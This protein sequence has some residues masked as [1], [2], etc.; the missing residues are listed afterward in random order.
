MRYFKNLCLKYDNFIDRVGIFFESYA[1]NCF[2]ISIYKGL[3]DVIYCIYIA[4]SHAFFSLEISIINTVNGW[5]A[6]FV[7]IPFVNIY[8]KQ[9]TCSAIIMIALNMIYFIPITTYCGYGGGSSSFLFFDFMY[10]AIL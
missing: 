9:K 1:L 4:G 3:L 10:L 2:V 6:V 7:M 5:L 8:Y